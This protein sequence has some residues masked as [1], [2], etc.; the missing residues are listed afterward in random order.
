[1]V[2]AAGWFVGE[3]H[4]GMGDLGAGSRAVAF[5]VGTGRHGVYGAG[6]HAVSSS[7]SMPC[8]RSRSRS[9]STSR[10]RRWTCSARD[11][12]SGW[13]VSHSCWRA[14]L[15]ASNCPF[16]VAQRPGLLE[17]W[18]VDGRL[19]LPPHLRQLHL[20]PPT[21]PAV[22]SRRHQL[23]RQGP[24]AKAAPP[25][26]PRQPATHPPCYRR[27]RHRLGFRSPAHFTRA[28]RAHSASHAEFRRITR[29][30]GHRSP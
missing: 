1:M 3:L 16:A 30:P 12:R 4:A 18:G 7:G 17:V 21:P 9:R 28:F 14:V 20:S 27:D 19:L 22:R 13:A 2:S 26:R 15:P 10:V 23:R 29:T 24:R 6:S 25:R 11:T 5:A 8:W